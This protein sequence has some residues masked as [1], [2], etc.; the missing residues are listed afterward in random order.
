MID[1]LIMLFNITKQF[2]RH[3][4]LIMCFLGG[5][6]ILCGIFLY[7]MYINNQMQSLYSQDVE[8][9]CNADRVLGKS[10]T[11]VQCQLAGKLAGELILLNKVDHERYAICFSWVIEKLNKRSLLNESC[12]IEDIYELT[13]EQLKILKNRVDIKNKKFS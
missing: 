10:I 7:P 9:L 1:Q 5:S 13:M 6:A 4:W 8:V 2:L 3:Y 12:S 11:K